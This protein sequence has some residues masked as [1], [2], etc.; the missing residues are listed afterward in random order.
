MFSVILDSN[1]LGVF[2][3]CEGLGVEVVVEQREEGGNNEFIH[4]LPVRLKYTNVKLT[5]PIDHQSKLV[6]D[7]LTKMHGK[8]KRSTARIT[9]LD[10]YRIPITSWTLKGVMP[11]RW[12]GPSMTADGNKVA[13]ETL[14]LAHH[15]F[16][17]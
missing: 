8:L 2:A 10:T 1:P 4:Q 5:R 14:E 16:L 3:S 6:A 15:G 12:Q 9:A 13:T 7:W 11:V 17:S